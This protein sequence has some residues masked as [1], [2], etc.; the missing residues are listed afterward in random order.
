MNLSPMRGGNG[1]SQQWEGVTRNTQPGTRLF[2]VRVVFVSGARPMYETIRAASK[3]EAHRFAITRY[4]NANPRLTKV[5]DKKDA[6][7][8]RLK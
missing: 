1:E 3:E 8:V 4:P 7:S 2:P 6:E 5:L